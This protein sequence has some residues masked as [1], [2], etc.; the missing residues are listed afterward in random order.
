MWWQNIGPVF[1]RLAV[2]ITIA[3]AKQ[4]EASEWAKCRR[5]LRP[6]QPKLIA[7]GEVA[8]I[9]WHMENA[10]RVVIEEVRSSTGKLRKIGEL[11]AGVVWNYAQLKTMTY[12][13]DCEGAARY[14]C[15]SVSIRVREKEEK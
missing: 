3:P 13:L 5:L 4:G 2:L 8:T 14:S 15:A 9:L 10:T 7:P 11:A 6:D 12:V 1:S